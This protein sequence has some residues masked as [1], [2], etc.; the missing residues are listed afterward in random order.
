MEIA[1]SGTALGEG[2]LS[3]IFW[4]T[5]NL[6]S[7]SNL[8][9]H[10]AVLGN[11]VPS[12]G[13]FATKSVRGVF[14][15]DDNGTTWDPIAF[16]GGDAAAF[17]PGALFA[18]IN[19][20]VNSPTGSGVSFMASAAGGD[21]LNRS[22]KDA[23]WWRQ[24]RGDTLQLLA[25]EG[26]QPPGAPIGAQWMSFISLAYPGGDAGPIFTAKL[27]H[28]IPAGSNRISAR[29]DIGLYARDGFGALRELLREGQL[30]LGKTVKTFSVLK[31][32]SGS[33]GVSRSFNANYQV[34]VLAS[35]TDG[36][37]AI[38]KIEIP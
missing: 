8:G 23:I 36:T 28:G 34:V 4:K 26:W 31:A 13:K 32:I 25:W 18:T 7:S 38:V 10:I 1:G 21:F 22:N 5:M 2:L 20:P 27:K 11:V 35:F 6:P 29:N 14:L 19:D 15:S 12:T 37:S 30:A 16:V 17:G 9:S 24:S 3:N 33:A